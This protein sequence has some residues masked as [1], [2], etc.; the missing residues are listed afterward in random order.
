MV[1]IHRNDNSLQIVLTPNRSMSWRGN[2]YFILSL[3]L[4]SGAIGLGFA[5][6]GA[7]VVLPFAGLEMLALSGALYYVSWKLNYRQVIHFKNNDL[8]I[9]KG[10][11]SPKKTWR[12][13]REDAALNIEPQ[14]HPWD[15]PTIRLQ[16]KQDLIV[17]GE[18]LSQADHT[19]LLNTL[20]DAGLYTRSQSASGSTTF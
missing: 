18:F 15:A 11:Y 14:R 12:F 3:L 5:L 13:K 2:Q 8:T 4:L 20:R 6:V 19:Q 17:I 1:S 7:W 10:Y 16:H 9:E